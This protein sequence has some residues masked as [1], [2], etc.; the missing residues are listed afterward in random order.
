MAIIKVRDENGKVIDIPAFAGPKGDPGADYVLT[1]EDKAEIAA[2]AVELVEV[3]TEEQINGLIDTALENFDVHSKGET[4]KLIA[5]LELIEDVTPGLNAWTAFADGEPFGELTKIV[6][7]GKI[8][9]ASTNTAEGSSN[10]VINGQR[11]YPTLNY[12]GQKANSSRW[13][14]LEVAFNRFFAIMNGGVNTSIP[15]NTLTGIGSNPSNAMVCF[16][17]QPIT[18]VGLI[19]HNAAAT[20][21]GAGTD[22]YIWGVQ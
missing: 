12:T 14:I 6:I 10:I 3:P 9:G 2:Q 11:F 19:F 22:L 15:P 7:N 5:H 20:G 8:V 16:E 21:F 17:K 4:Y 1:E 13:W 18:S